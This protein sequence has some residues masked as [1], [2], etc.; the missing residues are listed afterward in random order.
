M[1]MCRQALSL[2]CVY[3]C[4]L[5]IHKSLSTFFSTNLLVFVYRTHFYLNF[6]TKNNYEKHLLN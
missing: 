1:E 6:E 4:F 2:L 3:V 5:L